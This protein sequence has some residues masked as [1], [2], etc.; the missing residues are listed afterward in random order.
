MMCW[1]Q[2]P[3][4]MKKYAWAWQGDKAV[5]LE[6]NFE[7][8]SAM[9]VPKLSNKYWNIKYAL[10]VRVSLTHHGIQIPPS[11]FQPSPKTCAYKRKR[12]GN[13]VAL[14]FGHG[15]GD[16]LVWGSS[17]IME[18]VWYMHQILIPWL[19]M[20][21]LMNLIIWS[22]N[23]PTKPSLYMPRPCLFMAFKVT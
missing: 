19:T 15:M 2:R 18:S 16:H 12:V 14:L 11:K 1:L 23:H 5:L 21:S 10:K 13:Q 8:S 6:V 22:P 9:L 7:E 20:I 4:T 3:T 17:F